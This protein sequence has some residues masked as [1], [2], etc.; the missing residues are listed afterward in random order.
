MSQPNISTHSLHIQCVEATFIG[1]LF[2]SGMQGVD[3]IP[4]SFKS[5][6]QGIV[7]R[8]IVLAIRYNSHWGCV[9]ISRRNDLMY[10]K[11]KYTSLGELVFDFNLSYAKS[12]HT[13]VSCYV[14]LPFSHDKSVDAPVKWRVLKVHVQRS[15]P[16]VINEKLSSFSENINTM[17]DLFRSNGTLDLPYVITSICIQ[18]KKSIHPLNL[19]LYSSFF[20][21]ICMAGC[22]S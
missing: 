8:H 9:G 6:C 15:T 19:Y 22:T 11:L 14:G 4:L 13:L 2:T 3:R 10:K 18:K 5:K 20:I 16:D 12:F 17:Y 1:C 21:N 7:Y